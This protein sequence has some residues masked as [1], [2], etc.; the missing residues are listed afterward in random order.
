MPTTATLIAQLGEAHAQ[1]IRCD[2]RGDGSAR[3]H[4]QALV[5]TATAL[6]WHRL[7]EE[8]EVEI[9]ARDRY[10]RRPVG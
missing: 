4:A 6:L 10:G 5:D 1:R 9:Q 8:W 3:L 2:L 7:Y